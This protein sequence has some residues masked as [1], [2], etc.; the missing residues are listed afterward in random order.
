MSSRGNYRI[1]WLAT[2]TLLAATGVV[3]AQPV[4][5]AEREDA[6]RWVET[7]FTPERTT[8]PFSFRFG[9]RDGAPMVQNFG[10]EYTRRELDP[11]RV[12]HQ[13]LFD[14]P[15]LKL[16][17]RCDAIEYRDFPTVEWTVYVTNA[18]RRRSPIVAALRA[19]DVSLP[20]PPTMTGP[21]R[22]VRRWVAGDEWPDGGM[23][24]RAAWHMRH[25]AGGQWQPFDRLDTSTHGG[26]ERWISGDHPR[27]WVGKV[28]AGAAI[29]L[30]GVVVPPES[31]LVEPAGTLA[32]DDADKEDANADD[33]LALVW[34]CPATGYYQIQGRVHNVGIGGDG[35][36]WHLAD[37]AGNELEDGV[38][39]DQRSGR[40]SVDVGQLVLGDQVTVVI[41]SRD[42]AAGDLSIV[43]LVVQQ[44]STPVA[45]DLVVRFPRGSTDS[46]TDFEP[47]AWG[48]HNGAAYEL[49]PQGGRPSRGLYMPYFNIEGAEGGTIV[50]VGWPGQWQA[51]VDRYDGRL[52]VHVGLQSL[53]CSLIPYQEVRSP[54]VVMQFYRGDWRRAQNLWRQWMLK[55]N[56]P[57]PGG[58]RLGPQLTASSFH[59]ID[60]LRDANQYNQRYFIHRYLEERIPLDYWSIDEGWYQNRGRRGDDEAWNVHA[61]RFPDGLRYVTDDAR[62]AGVKTALR[63]DPERVGRD[64]RLYGQHASWLLSPKGL[65]AERADELSSRMLDLGRHTP[66]QWLLDHVDQ[67]IKSAGIAR[68]RHAFQ[69]DPL[70]F[71]RSGDEPKERG[72]TENKYVAGYLEYLDELLARNPDLVI[73]SCAGGGRYDL[74]TLRRAV[75]LE[76]SDRFFDPVAGQCHTYGMAY[77][78]PYWGTGSML[79]GEYREVSENAPAEADDV[80]LFRS[81]MGPHLTAYWDVNRRDLNWNLRRQLVSQWRQVAPY[82]LGDFHP[83]TEYSTSQYDWMAWQFHDPEQQAGMIQAF[84]RRRA[85]ADSLTVR[86]AALDP[87]AQYTLTNLDTGNATELS[88]AELGETGLELDVP[89][90]PGSALLVY[91][92]TESPDAPLADSATQ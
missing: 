44:L 23:T 18:V 71:W 86:L 25:R 31:L 59:Q 42:D 8:V 45:G 29:D 58:Q 17:V 85:D 55:H 79:S 72:G 73:D 22:N 7:Y 81:Q 49:E 67:L 13:L 60:P 34:T 88:G 40:F 5:D 35:V 16:R 12:H 24:G 52:N 75:P 43:D 51:S 83:L 14:D 28:V 46:P 41:G 74:E 9:A 66:R 3:A 87:D 21:R 78:L 27:P 89:T 64:S 19:L 50:G 26:L 48:L 80:Y 15:A 62:A 90:K 70:Y 91:R 92:K 63:F 47:I 37:P 77:W 30:D 4:L 38:V 53:Y 54:R 76:R 82:Y 32:A 65:P 11:D 68:Y 69:M 2:L 39:D 1:G 20:T 6:H 57:R 84:R 10:A 36:D 33:G 56:L 61:Q